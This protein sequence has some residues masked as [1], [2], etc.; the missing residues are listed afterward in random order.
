M[1]KQELFLHLQSFGIKL[2]VYW[3]RKESCWNMLFDGMTVSS[4]ATY[5]NIQYNKYFLSQ[6]ESDFQTSRQICNIS[7]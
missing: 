3:H 6:T 4:N 7:G 1:Q 5:S 2:A